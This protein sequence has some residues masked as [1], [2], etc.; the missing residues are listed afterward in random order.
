MRETKEQIFAAN[1]TAW[2]KF[3]ETPEV[4]SI[5]YKKDRQLFLST[6]EWCDWLDKNC[7][8]WNIAI[9][10]HDPLNVGGD[11][12]IKG[13]REN[14]PWVAAQFILHYHLNHGD[15]IEVDFDLANPDQGLLPLILHG[16]EYL[17]YRIP[18]LVGKPK[19]ITNPMI[20]KKRLEKR[21]MAV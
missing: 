19:A 16:F 10:D 13:W 7:S 2:C 3:Y 12:A 11:T 8:R 15:F 6:T 20:V 9:K 5:E 1:F 4:I 21:G 18:T 14:K 17:R